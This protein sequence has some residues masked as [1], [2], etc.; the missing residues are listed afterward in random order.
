MVDRFVMWLGA[1][2]LAVG[3]SAA[4]VAGA[5]VVAADTGSSSGGSSTS[6]DS[7]KPADSQAD[8]TK[9][10]HSDVGAEKPKQ[11]TAESVKPKAGKDTAADTDETTTEHSPKSGSTGKKTNPSTQSP[12]KDTKTTAEPKPTV[13]ADTTVA[14]KQ[15][16]APKTDAQPAVSHS[17]P[18]T[19]TENVVTPNSTQV[20]PATPTV[21]RV[22]TMA[23]AEKAT[24]A[25]T[26]PAAPSLVNIIGT[27]IFTLYNVATRL[28]E[29]PPVLPAG[30]TVTVRTSTLHID[31]GPGYDLPANWYFP[32]DQKPTGL[33]YLQ[34]GFLASAPFYSYTAA[35]LAEQT[36]SIVVAPSVTSNFFA[37]DGFWLGGAPYEQAVADLF[38]GDRA[39]LTDS[40]SA[41][42]GHAVTLPQRVVI[43][44][45]SAGGGL[46]LAAAGYMVENGT[47]GDLAGLVL[48]DGVAMTNASAVIDKIPDNL[49]VY[50]I[51]SPP[52]AWNMF[53][54]T[55]DA[56]VKARPGR[57]N[58]VELVGGSHIDA[59]QGGNPL[60]QF[61]AYLVAG[62]SQPQ[63][64]DAVKILAVGWINDMFAGNQDTGIYAKP[65]QTIEIPTNAGAAHAIALPAPD[66][67]LS[68]LDQFLRWLFVAGS[69]LLF[70]AT[71]PAGSAQPTHEV[72]AA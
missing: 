65:G 14:T 64:I 30:S 39:A 46:A 4:V 31:Y 49:P 57:F 19:T 13:V 25:A 53:G 43:A 50:Q 37:S 7:S 3:M 41:A 48:L 28:F 55:S 2:L 26:A 63:N 9:T 20:K 62:F 47:I 10:E 61:G 11:A 16:P 40:A 8:S 15:E 33:I 38:V 52:Y 21:A 24:A 6:S 29:G 58:G 56:L 68:P 70:N 32:A 27:L 71:S 17:A 18:S 42:L 34:H 51:S 44:G 59:M 69:Q 45:H 54:T 72:V 66:D 67:S 1:G 60:I 12:S 36:H 23:A 5:P 22:T 35:T